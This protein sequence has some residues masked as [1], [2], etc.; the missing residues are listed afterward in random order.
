[1][2]QEEDLL[3]R[4]ILADRTNV[5]PWLVY[6]DWLQAR[7]DPRGE[8]ISIE[9]ALRVTRGDARESLKQRKQQL[10]EAHRVRWLGA[11]SKGLTLRW[12]W[13]YVTEVL[14]RGE[15]S[16]VLP[17]LLARPSL[18]FL[19]SLRVHAGHIQPYVL[20]EVLRTR[21]LRLEQL[22]L[23]NC[24]L[25][26][27]GAE[28]LAQTPTLASLKSLEL[29][30]NGIHNTGILVNS[31][32]LRARRLNLAGNRIGDYEAKELTE[33]L[34]GEL[35]ELDL[36]GNLLAASGEEQVKDFCLDRGISLRL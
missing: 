17:S 36:S 6:G 2:V 32:F 20:S 21:A 9:Q 31:S 24:N 18:Q 29:E 19:K 23:F 15:Q 3:Q 35:Q 5:A 33:G 7:G 12:Q 16:E 13:G 4:A 8:L 25:G 1:M 34:W 26:N 28:V 22:E 14:L 10:I 11:N 27:Q 30:S